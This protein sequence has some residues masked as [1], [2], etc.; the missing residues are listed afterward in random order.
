MLIPER[1]IYGLYIYQ[2]TFD[3]YFLLLKYESFT[4]LAPLQSSKKQTQGN[5]V[6]VYIYVKYISIINFFAKKFKFNIKINCNV[7]YK[8]SSSPNQM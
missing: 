5:P 2:F 1:L 7:V 6:H 8:Y 3:N 4:C